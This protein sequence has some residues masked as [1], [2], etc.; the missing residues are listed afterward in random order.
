MVSIIS[1]FILVQLISIALFLPFLHNLNAFYEKILIIVSRLS[2][3]EVKEEIRKL[4]LIQYILKGD[5]DFW[6]T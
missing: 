5:D 4:T 2:S 3:L 6:L 1:A